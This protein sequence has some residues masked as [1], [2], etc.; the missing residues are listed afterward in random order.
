MSPG[1]RS[2]VVLKGYKHARLVYA[3]IS[4]RMAN[5]MNGMF[6]LSIPVERPSGGCYAHESNCIFIVSPPPATRI[7]MRSRITEIKF[8]LIIIFVI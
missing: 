1:F 8:M 4:R 5:K 3:R 6:K 2:T 7:L